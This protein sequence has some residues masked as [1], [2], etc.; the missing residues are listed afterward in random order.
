MAPHRRLLLQQLPADVLLHV[1]S[2]L[3]PADKL[4]V[5]ACCRHFRQLA[6]SRRLWRGHTARLRFGRGRRR[7]DAHFWAGLARRGVRSAVVQ[8]QD[9]V[10]GAT[11][12][13]WKQ[14][15][16]ALPSL[17]A[18]AVDGGIRDC[19]DHL[20]RFP[21]LS[22]LALR[23]SPPRGRAPKDLMGALRV[24]DPERVTRIGLCDVSFRAHADLP[25]F[26]A[27]FANLTWFSYHPSGPDPRDAFGRVVAGLPKLRHLSWAVRPFSK[28][29][30][31]PG[32]G[33]GGT[34]SGET[35]NRTL[36]SLELVVYDDSGLAHD[37]TRP[38]TRLRSLAVVYMDAHVHQGGRLNTWLDHAPHLSTLVVHG[39]PAPR[40][41]AR[42]IPPT[43]R[44]LTVRAGRLTAADLAAVGAQVPGLVHLEVDPWPPAA[45]PVAARFFPALQSVHLR[46]WQIPE[47]DLDFLDLGRF[48]SLR[49][50]EVEVADAEEPPRLSELRRRLQTLTGDRVRVLA[51]PRPRRDPMACC[52][53]QVHQSQD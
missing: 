1:L 43:V 16:A 23:G 30:S 33:G 22:C 48:Q 52:H 18:L 19:E 27:R 21:N 26:L 53:Q 5:R 14:L 10:Q 32:P 15:A 24:A 36:T 34:G 47:E 4:A 11:E 2:F 46:L 17:S 12:T 35:V 29:A 37:A 40:D 3:P 6:D 28:Y 38:L 31:G 51:A 39:G 13:H 7:Y 9:Q 20:D 25:A 50:V 45:G 42:S 49:R 44:G 41:Y 8:V